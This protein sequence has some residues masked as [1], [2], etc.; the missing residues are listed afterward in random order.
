[1]SL[2]NVLKSSLFIMSE[3]SASSLKSWFLW[4]EYDL[5]DKRKCFSSP[6]VWLLQSLH[7]RSFLGVIGRVYLPVSIARWWELIRSFVNWRHLFSREVNC[8]TPLL[9]RHLTWGGFVPIDRSHKSHNSS[10][11]YPTV[12]MCTF[13]LQTRALWWDMELPGLVHWGLFF[14]P[15]LV[16]QVYQ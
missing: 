2:K 8:S 9:V 7:Q 16:Q 6:I 11:K 15:G 4:L 5:Q 12:H 1:M 10:E 14:F 13:L 3:H